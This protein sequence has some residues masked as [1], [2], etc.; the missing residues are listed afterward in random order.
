MMKPWG[1]ATGCAIFAL[2]TTSQ[3]QDVAEPSATQAGPESPAAGSGGTQLEEIVVTAQR[4]AERLQNV[5][6]AVTA[7]TAAQ[8]ENAGINSTQALTMVTPGLSIPQ[9]SGYA[10]PRIRGVGSTVNGPGF[11]PPVAT[12]IDGVYMAAAPASLMTLNN[13][14]R[15][16]VLKGPQGTLFGRNATGGLIQVITK[17]P[18]QTPSGDVRVSYARYQN[19]TAQGYLTG[20]ITDSL[21]GDL[22]VR[23]ED[24]GQGWG[25]NL[26]T[27]KPIGLLHHDFAGRTKLLFEPAERTAIRLSIDYEDRTSSRQ[28]QKPVDRFYPI[29]YNNPLF[30]GPFALGGNYDIDSEIDPITKLRSGGVSLQINQEAG[31]VSLQ[32]ITA[33]RASKY[34]LLL[35]VDYLPVAITNIRDIG[36]N[37]QF[38][39]ELQVSSVASAPLKWVAGLFYFHSD[40]KNDPLFLDFGPSLVSPVPFVP[41]Q[42]DITDRQ[43]TDSVAGYTQGTYEIWR[44]T[45]LTLGGRYTHERKRVSGLTAFSIAGHQV[46]ATP[47]PDPALGTSDELT[48]KRFNYRIALDHKIT[49]DVMAYASYGTGFKSGGFN[50]NVPDDAPYKPEKIDAAEVGLKTELFDHRVRLNTSVYYYTYKNLQVGR[51]IDSNISIY[52]GA[53]ARIRGFDLDGQFV[54]SKQLSLNAGLAYTH[55]RFTSFPIA[56]FTVPVNGCVP[57]LGGVC[58][59]SANGKELPFTPEI[60]FDI[61]ADYQVD[62]PGGS[63]LALNATYYRS[64]RF[65][66]ASDNV[67]FQPAY[68]LV[69]TSVTWTDASERFS[70]RIWGRNLTDTLYTTTI[71]QSTAGNVFAYGEPRTYGV[72]LGY[73]F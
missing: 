29:T 15:I 28:A 17:D 43:L 65:Y 46:A 2:S 14:S 51:Y 13:I 6:I 44:D 39:Q 48:F 27:G 35:D 32:S 50:L 34:D 8:L 52:N 19:V 30:G 1:L 54:V 23:Y 42:I 22:A 37:E 25:T 10:Q 56:D 21:A 59:G 18:E 70:T 63:S 41:V 64:S 45:N 36:R 53:R 20:G 49:P 11:E 57:V 73:R 58:T 40:D 9:T 66:G 33:Y 4:R 72:T 24:Q 3:A 62:L 55:A 47:V 61:G 5:P 67:S 71:L 26:G 31:S 68:D 69:N 12:Y 16:E 60:T 7:T 38:S